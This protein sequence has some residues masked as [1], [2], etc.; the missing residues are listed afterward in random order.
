MSEQQSRDEYK[1]EEPIQLEDEELAAVDISDNTLEQSDKQ[2][3]HAKKQA[4]K[5]AK[6]LRTS[7]EIKKIRLKKRLAIVGLISLFIAGLFVVP[8]TRWPILNFIG[9]RSDLLVTVKEKENQKAVGLVRLTLEDGSTGTADAFGKIRFRKQK[10]GPHTLNAQK[11]GYGTVTKE[12]VNSFGTTSVDVQ[13]KVIGIQ[14]NFD[15]KNWLSG[16]PVSGA[17]TKFAKSTAS[18]DQDGRASLVIP[19]TDKQKVTVEISAPGY[20]TKTVETDISVE[21]RE[22]SLVSAQ[23]NYFLSKREGKFDIFSSNLDG[24]D[25]RKII[26]ATGKE[27]Q[28]LLQFTV[29]KSNRQAIL[30]ANRDGMVQNGRLIAGVYSVDLEKA[31]LKKIDQGSDIQILDWGENIIVYTKTDP[32]LN[33][34]DP[35]LSRLMSYNITS[36]KLS[37]LSQTN[38]FA[39][40]LLAQNKAYFMPSDPYRSIEGAV[41]TSVDVIS[42][43]KKTYLSG[44]QINYATRASYNTLELQDSSGAHF[45]L[46]VANGVTKAIERRPN[47]NFSFANSPNGQIAAWTDKRDG[48]GALIIKDLKSNQDKVLVKSPGITN[49]VRFISDDMVVVRVATSEETADYV[50]HLSSGKLAKIIDVSNVG[51]IR[52][53]DL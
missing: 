18:S 29:H 1:S 14:L 16:Q 53:V 20:L 34:D 23:K 7:A 25:Q 26:D 35:A 21:S 45:E 42:G 32:T 49:P 43:A 38:Y 28:S 15:L 19:P 3:K 46:Q 41:L 8:Y 33:Y 22:V 47:L 17:I 9:F 30:V 52:Q 37:E 51:I 10:L 24:S 12:L 4:K 11:T 31:S 40:S 48:Q 5:D 6:K 36:G 39:V 2:I 27:E 50:V 13:M 44:K